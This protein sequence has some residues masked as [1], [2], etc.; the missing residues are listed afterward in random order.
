[1]VGADVNGQGKPTSF[2]KGRIDGVRLSKGAVYRGGE[3]FTPQ[4]RL[5]ADADTIF[6]TNMDGRIGASVWGEGP[7]RTIGQKLGEPV[8]VPAE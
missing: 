8:L 6:L 4:R 1:M 2:F 7:M 5:A 3:A